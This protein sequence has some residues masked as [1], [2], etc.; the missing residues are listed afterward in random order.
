[1]LK[2]VEIRSC[3][4][5]SNLL[6]ALGLLT[7][8][9]R[10]VVWGSEGSCGPGGTHVASRCGRPPLCVEGGGHL[11]E[12]QGGGRRPQVTHPLLPYN[13]L[14]HTPPRAHMHNR[15]RRELLSHLSALRPLAA[16]EVLAVVL[17]KNTPEVQQLLVDPIEEGDMAAADDLLPVLPPGVKEVRVRV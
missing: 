11:G 15:V 1:M 3:Q 17:M 9:T 5:P 14:A 8:L 12:M 4:L 2:S 16:L 10:L 13:S 6:P 7:G